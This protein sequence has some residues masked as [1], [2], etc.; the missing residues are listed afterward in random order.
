MGMSFTL[1]PC[2]VKARSVTGDRPVSRQLV[3]HT[4]IKLYIAVNSTHRVPK[5]GTIAIPLP[6]EAGN[7][8]V[9]LSTPLS[10]QTAPNHVQIMFIS[11]PYSP[12]V[13]TDA[14]TREINTARMEHL[15]IPSLP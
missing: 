10:I 4:P 6:R 2:T 9:F 13:L 12:H 8:V 3:C 7:P 1:E 15:H 11:C 14:G 5:H